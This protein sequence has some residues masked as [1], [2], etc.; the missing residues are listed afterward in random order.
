MVKRNDVFH[1]KIYRIDPEYYTFIS[2]ALISI[3]ISLLFEIAENYM[4]AFFW[5]GFA[6]SILASFFCFKLSII[7]KGVNETYIIKKQGVG[8]IS[9]AWNNAI[10]EKKALC[11][12]CLVLTTAMLICSV[13]SIF[14]MQIIDSTATRLIG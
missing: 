11:T 6:L 2:G 5:I 1:Y 9:T 8:N 13:I 3:P 4:E 7:L 14:L 12:R 10:E